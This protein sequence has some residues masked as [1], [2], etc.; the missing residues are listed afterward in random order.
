MI[1]CPRSKVTTS[2]TQLGAHEWLIY[3]QATVSETTYYKTSE[4]ALTK[5]TFQL[6][7]KTFSNYISICPLI[8]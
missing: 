3:L 4:E 2:A 5:K 1:L 6:T 8:E 7:G